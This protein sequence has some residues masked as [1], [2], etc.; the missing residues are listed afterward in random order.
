[1]EST[2]FRTRTNPD[3]PNYFSEETH[4]K[5]VLNRVKL[6]HKIVLIICIFVIPIA[7]LTVYFVVTGINHD[8]HFA[9]KEK[10]GTQYQRPLEEL[11]QAIP[12]CHALALGYLSGDKK[13]KEKLIEKEAQIDK[14]FQELISVDIRLGPTL[15]F[16][17]DGLSMR[18]RQ[19]LQAQSVDDAWRKLKNHLDT[20]TVEQ[21]NEPF[22]KLA[23]NI[24]EMLRHMGDTSNLVL[25]PDLDSR[26]VMDVTLVTLP[27]TQARLASI[28]ASGTAILQ[29]KTIT[30]KERIQLGVDA[31]ML[32]ES[33]MDRIN[34]DLRTAL[35][36]DPLTYGTSEELQRHMPG[37]L[38]AYILANEA[39][40]DKLKRMSLS[41][42]LDVTPD[43]FTDAGRDA[44][45]ASF[46]FWRIAI[47]ELDTLLQIRIDAKNEHRLW[48]LGIAT[49]S[50]GIAILLGL[51]II[52]S[53]T[54]PLNTVTEVLNH[55]AELVQD[56]AFQ[57]AAASQTQAA[58][59]GEQAASLEE[60]SS[61]L[62][63]MAATARQN[64]Q[65][66]QKAKEIA[67][68]A[69]TSAET[70]SADMREMSSAMD[71]I[72]A[73]S[74]GIAKIIKTID[75][76][77]FQTNI[78]AL[79]AAVEAARAGE[80]GM[81]FA[82]VADEVRNLAQR[83]AQAAKETAD[84]IEDAI[85]KS[86]R[87]VQIS[88][89]VA[90]S[91]QDIVTKARQVDEL[92]A[93]IAT[94]S[95]EQTQ[96]IDHVNIAVNQ[97]DKITQ[98]NSTSAEETANAAETL[99]TQVASLKESVEVLLQI[100]GGGNHAAIS[101]PPAPAADANGAGRRAF[102]QMREPVP[103][104]NTPA[105]PSRPGAGRGGLPHRESERKPRLD[106]QVPTDEDFKNF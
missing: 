44:R 97:M 74:D 71:A 34:A 53:I 84:K 58:G 39:F 5:N 66:A 24:R 69:R 7:S 2:P 41:E 9:E 102:V 72:K 47:N 6:V 21:V 30:P 56:G 16:T 32:K 86:G 48:A 98:S 15:Q 96:G 50:L 51:S 64:S 88:A 37:A 55:S 67:N 18:T 31:A 60:T 49:V 87:G 13:L 27:Q 90:Q 99:N 4:M 11:F 83:S 93:G 73:S 77:A 25:D 65:N 20:L 59:A 22:Q 28:L 94:A 68:Q 76:I 106:D 54:R 63:E 12:E 91:L 101:T 3:P 14:L 1:M 43:D 8:I 42:K 85:Q 17:D 70:G 100:V 45:K 82:V 26:Y 19:G 46:D 92:V 95:Q 40:V 38:R 61:S 23:G 81:G 36:E 10:I 75:E 105:R 57:I 78:L 52:L 62:E 29:R 89:K 80:A 35:K 103:P 104:R 79:N 33:D